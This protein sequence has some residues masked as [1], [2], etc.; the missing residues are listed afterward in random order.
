MPLADNPTARR[1][2]MNQTKS[3]A[4]EWIRL[5]QNDLHEIEL[6]DIQLQ[7]V[8]QKNIYK[9][10]T[11]MFLRERPEDLN[12]GPGLL[13]I[14]EIT[15]KGYWVENTNELVLHVWVGEQSKAIIIP[16]DGWDLRAGIVVH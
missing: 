9:T 13:P 3:N 1:R 16:H 7:P 8:V 15:C 10:I 5:G 6:E 14:G 12:R 4:S 2:P 11:Q